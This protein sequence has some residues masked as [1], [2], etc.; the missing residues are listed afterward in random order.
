MP[1]P[2]H[3]S[4]GVT[5][6]THAKATAPWLSPANEAFQV[7]LASVLPTLSPPADGSGTEG[8]SG[9]VICTVHSVPSA[10]QLNVFN[11]HTLENPPSTTQ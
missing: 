11:R 8:V 3:G 1:S 7:Q 2:V 10:V 9:L 5:L 6:N 4:D